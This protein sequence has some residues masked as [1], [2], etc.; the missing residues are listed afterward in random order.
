MAST[1]TERATLNDLP[2][3]MV[4]EVLSR[5]SLQDLVRFKMTTKRYLEILSV[6]RVNK[7]KV[8]VHEM[9]NSIERCQPNLFALQFARPTLSHLQHLT[10]DAHPN[11]FDLNQLNRLSRLAQLTVLRRCYILPEIQD[12][13]FRFRTNGVAQI[14]PDIN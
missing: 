6:F 10:I 3:E 2:T 7:L 11:P 1:A 12:L 9:S 8:G 14:L 13:N 5:L 4:C